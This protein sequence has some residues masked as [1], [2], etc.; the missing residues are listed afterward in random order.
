M[1]QQVKNRELMP[2]VTKWID[3]LR[4]NGFSIVKIKAKENGHEVNWER[5]QNE[6][7]PAYQRNPRKQPA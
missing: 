4:A 5:K 6:Q 2:Q 7:S 1:Q 3:D